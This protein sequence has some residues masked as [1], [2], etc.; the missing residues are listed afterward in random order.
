MH[1]MKTKFITSKKGDVQITILV[2]MIVAICILTIFSFIR[3]TNQVQSNYVGVGLI[4]E[5][6]ADVEKFYFY[7]NAG[8]SEDEAA[9]KI[10]AEIEN[11]R[12]IINREK[13]M[14][15]IKIIEVEYTMNIMQ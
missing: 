9:E 1:K 12:L 3:S 15:R 2:I 6:N 10:E 14:G 4:E 5:I 13:V 7:L 8:F 11:G